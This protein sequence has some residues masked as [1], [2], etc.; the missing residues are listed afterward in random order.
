MEIGIVGTGR[1]G[2]A[3][4]DCIIRAQSAEV[5]WI[6]SRSRE[7]AAEFLNRKT[8]E[9]GNGNIAIYSS[10]RKAFDE[11]NADAVIITSPNALHAEIAGEALRA[12]LDV[13]LEYPPAVTPS[14]GEEL[15]RLAAKHGQTYA[16][17]LTHLKE[18]KHRIMAEYCSGKTKLGAPRLY[19]SIFCSGNPISRWY[20]REEL[21]GGIF[22]SSLYHHIDEAMDFFGD[23]ASVQASYHVVKTGAGRIASDIGC[24]QL[25]FIDG[26]TAQ[27]AYARGMNRPGIGSR[28]S[29]VF[30]KGYIVEDRERARI[31]TPDG[32]SPLEY[33]DTDALQTEVDHFLALAN[34]RGGI[35]MTVHHAQRSLQVA[36]RAKQEA[37]GKTIKSKR[38]ISI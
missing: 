28:K 37:V 2:I 5:A 11:G 10:F 25:S 15:I 17:G 4:Y 36:Y 7:R 22:V 31:L 27:I 38:L 33:D 1:M 9:G 19:Q 8:R 30:E 12:G 18:G 13:F 29:I 3:R 24:I 6:C 32:T 26:C 35:D 20:D 23:P 16:I 21:S 14:K 34:T